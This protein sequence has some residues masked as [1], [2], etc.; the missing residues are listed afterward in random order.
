VIIGDGPHRGALERLAA[1]LGLADGVQFL[2]AQ[3]PAAV[4]EWMQRAAVL[5]APSLRAA[6]GDSEGLPNVVVESAA[7]GLPVVA[8]DH[9][10]IAEAVID[11][12]TGFIV[13]ERAVEPLA[14][15]LSEVLASAELRRRLGAE[16]RALAEQKFDFRRQMERLE[17]LYDSVTSTSAIATR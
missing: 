8:T 9:G 10:G 1:E 17:T 2:G 3:P 16:G 5:A 7:S 15:R 12:Q 11:G 6:D 4:V 14:V 13:P